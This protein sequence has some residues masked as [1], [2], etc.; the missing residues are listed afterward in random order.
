M[1]ARFRN[2]T[3]RMWK[4]WKLEDGKKNLIRVSLTRYQWEN[5]GFEIKKGEISFMYKPFEP[6]P[7]A[8]F[9]NFQVKPV[10]KR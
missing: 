10:T 2:I 7:G 9:A 3:P 8:L 4:L 1:S 5:L 6:N